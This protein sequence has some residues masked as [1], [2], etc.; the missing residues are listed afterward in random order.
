MQKNSIIKI[1]NY[2]TIFL[3]MLVITIPWLAAYRTH[4]ERVSESENRM[5]SPYPQVRI[6]GHINRSLIADYENWLSDNLRGRQK[7]VMVDSAIQYVLFHRIVKS[8]EIEGKDH[9]LFTN[10]DEMCSTYSHT[11]RMGRDRADKAINDF[12]TLNEY[13]LDKGISFI[14]F[15][16]CDK[17]TIYPENYVEGVNQV[18]DVTRSDRFLQYLAEDTD[19]R[20]ANPKPVLMDAKTNGEEKLYYSTYDPNHWNMSGAYIG[21]NVLLNEVADMCTEYNIPVLSREDY[22]ITEVELDKDL[23]GYAYPYK[24]KSLEYNISSPNAVLVSQG[25]NEEREYIHIPEYS[26]EYENEAAPNNLRVLVIN[27]SFIRMYLTD[28]IAESFAHTLS[29][30]LT[31]LEILDEVI[32]D[33]NP[34]IVILENTEFTFTSVLERLDD[35]DWL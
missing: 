10:S 31:N 15:P 2:I 21:Y 29:V 8:D 13:L 18:G 19:I 26:F 28:D 23:Y 6:D 22:L 25:Y 30:D 27:D 3:F 32:D 34:D 33:Y 9:W 5:L 4:D 14:Y 20:V 12:V 16:C 35:A 11:D 24:D 7:I 17:V 1:I